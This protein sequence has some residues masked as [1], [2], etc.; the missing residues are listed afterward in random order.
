MVPLRIQKKYNLQTSYFYLDLWPF[1]D[2][3]MYVFD[4]DIAKQVAQDNNTPKHRSESEF[5][6]HLSGPGSLVALEGAQWKVST[7]SIERPRF[8]ASC[9]FLRE[10]MLIFALLRDRNGAA[11]SIPAFKQA[12][13]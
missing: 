2:P 10:R 5:M 4:P 8:M 1:N 6:Y 3:I 12:I 7:L 13:S 9:G 11:Y